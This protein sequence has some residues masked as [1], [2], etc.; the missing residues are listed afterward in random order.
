[1]LSN[2]L[3]QILV[4][5]HT[6]LLEKSPLVFSLAANILSLIFFF[7]TIKMSGSCCLPFKSRFS[8]EKNEICEDRYK[9]SSGLAG[10]P[11]VWSQVTFFL[12]TSFFSSIINNIYLKGIFWRKKRHWA[13][14]PTLKSKML[15]KFQRSEI[16]RLLLLFFKYTQIF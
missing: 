12:S 8:W 4:S 14:K 6:F 15:Q 7:D 11:N 16:K 1:M 3:A 5:S 10:V 2:T 9:F 13:Y